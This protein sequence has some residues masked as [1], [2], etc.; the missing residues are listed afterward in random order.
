VDSKCPQGEI[1][2]VLGKTLS[3][4]AE[5]AAALLAN[6]FASLPPN[7]AGYPPEIAA[8]VEERVRE[9]AVPGSPFFPWHP[10][11]TS[12]FAGQGRRDLRSL[13]IFT[14][15]PF[16]ARDLDDAVHIR[17]VGRGRVE[18]GVH[19]ADVTAFVRPGTAVDDEALA[20]TTT[21]YLV[22]RASPACPEGLSSNAC[23]LLPDVPR[24]AVSCVWTIVEE[25]G[26]IEE[27][28]MG[29]SIIESAAKLSYGV[30]QHAIDGTLKSAWS[31]AMDEA[32]ID[33]YKGCL[34]PYAGMTV[35]DVSDA[36]RRL[37]ALAQVL[38]SRRFASGALKLGSIKMGFELNEV[39]EPVSVAPYI[40]KEA[41]WMIE[42]LMLLANRR[43]AAFLKE[44]YAT[45]AFIR[46]HAPPDAS[47]M[48]EWMVDATLALKAAALR[49][50]RSGKTAE[51]KFE[52][53]SSAGL[54]AALA[55]IR[56][57]V[58]PAIFEYLQDRAVRPMSLAKYYRVGALKPTERSHFALAFPDYTHFTSP[59]RRYADVVV[60]RQLLAA[61]GDERAK[62]DLAHMEAAGKAMWASGK[63]GDGEGDDDDGDDEQYVDVE[64]D[65]DDDDDEDGEG[66]RRAKTPMDMYLDSTAERCNEQRVKARD[67]QTY[68][69]SMCLAQFLSLRGPQLHLAIVARVQDRSIEVFFPNLG[70]MDRMFY[71]N[72]VSPDDADDFQVEV[73]HQPLEEEEADGE[74]G[75]D[76]ELTEAEARRAA[77][78][79]REPKREFAT[80][81]IT[82][83]PADAESGRDDESLWSKEVL[84]PMDAVSVLLAL[85]SGGVR[86]TFSVHL[87]P[88]GDARRK[89]ASDLFDA[90]HSR[91]VGKAPAGVL[92]TAT[93]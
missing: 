42:E 49:S 71:D 17:D 53:R 77:A 26:V 44:R 61:L 72:V 10:N 32:E 84:H 65:G 75:E 35:A 39:N 19:I 14:V 58:H 11:L 48:K 54:A 89:K 81:T 38:R 92:G 47:R 30:A 8:E 57:E 7:G 41:N 33:S 3:M 1:E 25:T 31:D 51:V 4:D 45:S 85:R 83:K 2:R 63:G 6:G 78:K 60:H 15:D 93:D 62:E 27:E 21:V 56:K 9:A 18:V 87:V 55:R 13:P 64:D 76:R 43:V 73:E 37:W 59:I 82:W 90:L 80:T 91:R 29:R 79:A 22:D 68:A 28:W 5:A 40:T 20:R 24:L 50:G 23:S 88:P 67:A 74:D 52:P 46:Q 69:L 36:V 12:E 86:P 70:I 16:T 66:A 34:G